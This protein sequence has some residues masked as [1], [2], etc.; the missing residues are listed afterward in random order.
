MV[1]NCALARPARDVRGWGLFDCFRRKQF[2]L[3]RIWFCS[4]SQRVNGIY[5]FAD[6]LE[7]P[8]NRGVPQVSDLINVTQFFKHSRPDHRRGNLA[9]A[10]LEFVYN[11]VY[12]LL[13]RKQTSGTLFKSLGDAGSK[14]ATVEGLMCSV[15]FYHAQIRTLGLFVS[16]VTIFAF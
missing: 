15:A 12:H 6:V 13:Q 1:C 14:F 3:Q 8:V 2:P 5:E 7:A 10:G 16:R 4:P 9:S 11:F